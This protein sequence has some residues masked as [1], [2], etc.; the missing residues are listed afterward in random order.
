VAE[1]RQDARLPGCALDGQLPHPTRREKRTQAR[2]LLFITYYHPPD[3]TGGHRWAAMGH[4]LRSLGYQVTTLTTSAWGTLDDDFDTDT[5]RTGD[6]MA[7]GLLRRLLRRPPIVPSTDPETVIVKR[8]LAVIPKIVVPDV[9]L[10]TWL[11]AALV[12]ARTLMRDRQIEC[13][14]TSG[15]M[16]STHLIGL[17]L[18]RERPAWIADFRDG[19]RY[20]PLR[21]PWPTRAQERLDAT[22][23]CR[24]ARGAEAVIGVTRPIAQDIS[25][26]LGI[27]ATHIPNGW[28]PWRDVRTS[29]ASKVE[30]EPGIV[31]VVHTGKLGGDVWRDP[32]PLFIAMRRIAAH[33]PDSA[34]RLRLVLAGPMDPRLSELLE[35]GDGAGVRYVGQLSREGSLALQRS[36]DALLLLTSP[37]H[38]SH[39]TGKLFEYLAAGKPIIALARGSE[40]GRIVQETG[41]GVVV[42]AND[43]EGIARALLAAVD[44]TLGAAY[45]PTGLQEYVYP[46]PAEAVAELVEHAIERRH[47][48]RWPRQAM[49]TR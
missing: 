46:G 12:A 38:V 3:P 47:R 22:M 16:H 36:A 42:G 11:P 35:D 21:P 41:T 4:W 37:H 49:W 24:V 17:L 9:G 28:D 13:V 31:T 32:E 10:V 23:E 20:E 43:V 40:A 27:A 45:S 6:L 39:A 25:G 15:P 7:S 48:Q 2:R 33:R 14:V 26:R 8:P 5:H 19:W 44:G 30:S 18:D 29:R 34:R 1:H